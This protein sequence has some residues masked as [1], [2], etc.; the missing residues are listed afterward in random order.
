MGAEVAVYCLLLSHWCGPVI[1]DCRLR[2]ETMNL[3]AGLT[4]CARSAGRRQ[5]PGGKPCFTPSIASLT[6]SEN[7]SNNSRAKYS[8]R[9]IILMPAPP[10]A[11]GGIR[12]SVVLVRLSESPFFHVYISWTNRCRPMLMKPITVNHQQVHVTVV[13]LTRSLV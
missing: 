4:P 6:T 9:L 1:V 12:Q 5:V 10:I 11:A 3:M 8:F 13:T 7:N 2:A